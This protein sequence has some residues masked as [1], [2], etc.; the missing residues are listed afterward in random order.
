[1][2]EGPDT[3]QRDAL[4]AYLQSVGFSDEQI[5]AGGDSLL[6]LAPRRVLFGDE[7]RVTIAEIAAKVGCDESLVR[8]VRLA[9]GL[10]DVGDHAACSPREVEVMTSF[11]LGAELFGEEVTLQFLRVVGAATAGVAEAALATFASNLRVPLVEGGAD[12]VDIARAGAEATAALLAVPPVL[13][14]LLRVHFANASAGR[15][16]GAD[17]S[18]LVEVAVGFVDLV[19]STEL[20]LSRSGEALARALSDFEGHASD[21]VVGVGGRIVK[22]IGDAVMFVTSDAQAACAAATSILDAVAA[23]P[24]LSTARGA[25]TW[26]HVLPRDGD[27]FGAAVN[28]AARAVALAEPGAI[29]VSSEVAEKLDP[30]LWL[31]T[32]LG[33]QS[34]KGFDDPVTLFQIGSA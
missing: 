11:L 16:A 33:E 27:Y 3:E 8:R 2:T 29:V 13:D 34:L 12:L 17:P 26:G 22:R 6:G 32:A 31:V 9:S 1:M 20:T 23:H 24:Q 30:D 21:V 18:P 28:L 15:F 5:A 7:T 4:I 10:P 25:V 19:Q 14:V